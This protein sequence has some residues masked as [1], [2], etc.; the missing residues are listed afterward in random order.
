MV[1]K[2]KIIKGYVKKINKDTKK[3]LVVPMNRKR[4]SACE[5]GY[6]EACVY[7]KRY[8]RIA[9]NPV[10]AQAGDTVML[11]CSS[12]NLTRVLLWLIPVLIAAGAYAAVY[13]YGAATSALMAAVSLPAG[14]A[15]LYIAVGKQTFF[16]KKLIITGPASEQSE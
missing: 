1:I 14:Y 5:V 16:Y 4:C 15:A 8:E 3:A 12:F 13:G 11:E 2:M 6:C 10:G 9:A 7:S